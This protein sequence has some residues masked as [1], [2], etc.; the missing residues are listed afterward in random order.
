[1]QIGTLDIDVSEKVKDFVQYLDSTDRII[2]SARFGDGK[3]HLLNALRCRFHYIF[4]LV[5]H[6]RRDTLQQNL[7]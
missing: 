5:F 1:M 7:R 4:H 2:L 3:T 6:P